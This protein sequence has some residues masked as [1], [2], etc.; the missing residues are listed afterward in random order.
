MAGPAIPYQPSSAEGRERLITV[1]R[2]P[3]DANEARAWLAQLDQEAASIRAQLAEPA[4]DDDWR[5][6][7]QRALTVK[8]AEI[9][10]LEGWLLR[11]E[12]ARLGMLVDGADAHP[13]MASD[14]DRWEAATFEGPRDRR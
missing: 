13:V 12:P 10:R 9:D 3:V 2:Q 5:R 14:L 11:H 7:A 8:V 1:G 6:R 4:R